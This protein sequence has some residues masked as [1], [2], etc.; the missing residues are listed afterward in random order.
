MA[1]QQRGPGHAGDD[2]ETKELL[3]SLAD[4]GC[5]SDKL[6]IIQLEHS[7]FVLQQDVRRLEADMHKRDLEAIEEISLL[8]SKLANALQRL[9]RENEETKRFIAKARV[10]KGVVRQMRQALSQHIDVMRTL[11]DPKAIA[12]HADILVQ[13]TEKVDRF[14]DLTPDEVMDRYRAEIERVLLNRIVERLKKEGFTFDV[15]GT[16]EKAAKP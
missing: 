6:R 13:F 2:D 11:P 4:L 12:A 3:K 1:I 14:F 10:S 5:P 8:K 16:I 15:R 9:G 7:N